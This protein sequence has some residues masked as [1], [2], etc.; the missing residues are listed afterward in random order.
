MSLIVSLISDC[1]HLAS[2]LFII[3]CIK[4]ERTLLPSQAACHHKTNYPLS[5]INLVLPKGH[6]GTGVALKVCTSV[7]QRTTLQRSR[8]WHLSNAIFMLSILSL[9]TPVGKQ[10]EKKRLHSSCTLTN[11]NTLLW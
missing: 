5:G 10:Y 6:L 2:F 3:L 1:V 7:N 8:L 9:K 4:V 11:H